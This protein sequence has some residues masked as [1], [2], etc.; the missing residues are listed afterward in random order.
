MSARAIGGVGKFPILRGGGHYLSQQRLKSGQIAP[1]SPPL[2]GTPLGWIVHLFS[3]ACLTADES[4][5][6]IFLFQP[7]QFVLRISQSDHHVKT[8]TNDILQ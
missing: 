3:I 7:V 8:K 5:A 6:Q 1:S 2:R 4:V